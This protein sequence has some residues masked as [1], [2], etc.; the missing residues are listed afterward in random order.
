MG[1]HTAFMVKTEVLH[2]KV[3]TFNHFWLSRGYL[4]ES[5][6]GQRS[7]WIHVSNFLDLYTAFP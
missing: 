1:Q 4:Q 6:C 5:G 2:W 7:R 3:E